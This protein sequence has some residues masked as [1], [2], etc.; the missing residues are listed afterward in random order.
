[1]FVV[2]L[3]VTAVVGLGAANQP[4]FAWATPGVVPGCGPAP[5]G[6]PT[7]SVQTSDRQVISGIAA[8]GCVTGMQTSS[9]YTSPVSTAA[10]V[11]QAQAAVPSTFDRGAPATLL[12]Y[13]RV[14]VMLLVC[15][16]VAAVG[17]GARRG[18][19]GVVALL[20]LQM[21]HK[22]LATVR[23]LFLSDAGAPLTTELPS[24]GTF[25]WALLGGTVLV[26]TSMLFTLKVNFQHRAELRRQARD[27][28]TTPPPEPLDPLTE[29]LGRKISKVR[30]A[31]HTGAMVNTP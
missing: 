14:V 21:P 17:V 18:W 16:T 31:T 27:A 2:L 22:D 25:T 1:M 11:A 23:A 5:A 9:Q 4:W 7:I 24:V 19:L 20:L 10:G 29:Y 28:G 26:F 8:R 6:S 15:L 13:P 3:L 12:G 30:D